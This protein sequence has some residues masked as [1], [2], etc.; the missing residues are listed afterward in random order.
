MDNI[1]S[2]IFNDGPKW[3][4]KHMFPGLLLTLI[5][6]TLYY[7]IFMTIDTNFFIL[8]IQMFLF[9]TFLFLVDAYNSGYIINKY[10]D[11][12]DENKENIS[13][14]LRLISVPFI[15]MLIITT[16][17]TSAHLIWLKDLPALPYAVGITL[18][19]IIGTRISYIRQ[20]E[21]IINRR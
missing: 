14:K 15:L 18:I 6:G 4:S 12:L 1:L 7:Y 21:K 13:F 11:E 20:G 10:K 3:M 5:P 9:T 2:R 16:I 8:L 17:M 19:F